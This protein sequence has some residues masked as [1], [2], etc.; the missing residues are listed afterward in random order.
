ML[1][2]VNYGYTFTPYTG[3]PP[4]PAGL[5]NLSAFPSFNPIYLGPV[6]DL[7]TRTP[8]YW[9]GQIGLGFTSNSGGV[10]TLEASM[11]GCAPNDVLLI[12]YDDGGLPAAAAF[13][14]LVDASG[15]PISSG[16]PLEVA[17]ASQAGGLA[18]D[19]SIQTIITNQGAI[20]SGVTIPGGGT[21]ELGML[22]YLASVVAGLLTVQGKVANGAS[23]SGNPV[24]AAGVDLGGLTR[25]ALSDTLGHL[26][27]GKGY[28][29]NYNISSSTVVKSGGGRV[30]KV[31]VIV[32]GAAGTLNDCITG[33]GQ[34]NQIWAI[35]ATAG[36]YDIDWPFATGLTVVP[37]ASQVVAV[38]Y[39]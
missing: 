3:S 21:G 30:A 27:I 13:T 7:N 22:H 39:V 36:I 26:L 16:H 20:G 18:L 4:V 23:F 6:I 9:P 32:G 5:L 35:P 29:Q 33:P 19:A 24:A 34:A 14:T 28:R 8:I 15:S 38:S 37:G 2:P 31:S 17:I 10:L 11:Q 12:L 25:Q 1:H